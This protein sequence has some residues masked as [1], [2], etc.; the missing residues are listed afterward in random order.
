MA[1][2]FIACK[3]AEDVDHVEERIL[4]EVGISRFV[5]GGCIPPQIRL[6]WEVL[7]LI[8]ETIAGT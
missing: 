2:V 3:D 7:I 4:D 6:S 8:G 1:L 5:E